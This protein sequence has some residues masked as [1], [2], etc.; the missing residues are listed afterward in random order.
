MKLGLQL[1]QRYLILDCI[2]GMLGYHFVSIYVSETVPHFMAV[3][4]RRSEILSSASDAVITAVYQL[5]SNH[6][7]HLLLS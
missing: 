5:M 2:P 6:M 4:G 1:P 3:A 7:W